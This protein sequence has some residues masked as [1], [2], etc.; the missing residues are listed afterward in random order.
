MVI[1]ASIP[2]PDFQLP[3]ETGSLHKLSDYRG[4]YVILYFYPK[5][6]T[7]G[8]TTE[9]CGFRDDYTLYQAAGAVVLGVSPDAPKSHI[10]F[11]L[12]YNL[13]YTLLSDVDHAVCEQ[14]GV[15]GLKI[16]MGREYMGVLRTTFIIAPDGSIQK[17]FENVKP[18]GHSSQILA[19]IKK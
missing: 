1:K 5:D 16:S 4:K 6:D 12:K 2:A 7:P 19:E 17:V 15:W 11:K 13:P 10:K 18:D 3:D 8:C 14:Y 9:A